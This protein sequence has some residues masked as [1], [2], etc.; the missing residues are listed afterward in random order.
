VIN[1]EQFARVLVA[2][3]APILPPGFAARADGEVVRIEADDGAGASTSLAHLD[4]DEAEPQDYADAAWNVLSM[5]QDV[6]SETVTE[7]WPAAL[8]GTTDLAEPGAAAE[9]ASVRLFFGPED[10][11]VLTLRSIDL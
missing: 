2:R 6:V 7:P 5:V 8:D 3:L 4:P 9:G 11:P 10:R 1:P